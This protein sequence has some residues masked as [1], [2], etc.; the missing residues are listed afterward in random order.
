MEPT[1]VSGVLVEITNDTVRVYSVP[2]FPNYQDGFALRI[3]KKNPA[4]TFAKNADN[5]IDAS[6]NRYS[7]QLNLTRYTD[8]SQSRLSASF[9]GPCINPKPIF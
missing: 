7:G 2:L 5:T 6:V 1:D 9:E 3:F 4:T 8:A